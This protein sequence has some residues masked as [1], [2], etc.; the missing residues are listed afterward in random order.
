MYEIFV[1]QLH[2]PTHSIQSSCFTLFLF[3]VVKYSSLLQHLFSEP[4][5]TFY[6][7]SKQLVFIIS[8]RHKIP[9]VRDKAKVKTK[10]LWISKFSVFCVC[11]RCR[12]HS[13]ILLQRG[14]IRPN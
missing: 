8:S 3:V 12:V 13:Y 5:G 11:S 14:L 1:I 4:R 2:F 9:G 7:S 10:G 6:S